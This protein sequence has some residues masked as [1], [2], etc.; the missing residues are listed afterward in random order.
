M[1]CCAAMGGYARHTMLPAPYQPSSLS[2]L[3]SWA[4]INTTILSPA[5]EVAQDPSTGS[6]FAVVTRRAVHEGHA[7]VRMP[8]GLALSADGAVRALPKLL[9]PQMEAHVSIAAWFMRL[10]DVPPAPLRT[11][12]KSL[13]SDAEVD[14][15]LRWSD[16]ELALLQTSLA[17]F[18][19]IC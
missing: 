2:L 18:D 5:L 13:R 12:L 17:R 11:Y 14:C 1:A 19:L 16:E 7:L 10:I 3:D 9:T 15:T 8:S 6:G 4:R